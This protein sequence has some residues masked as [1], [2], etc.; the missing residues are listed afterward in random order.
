[1]S[2]PTMSDVARLAGVSEATVSRTLA[3][4]GKVA[5]ATRERVESAA[6]E[7]GYRV[8][9]V[10]R[11][12]R[13]G[14]ARIIGLVVSDLTNPFF[15]ALARSCEDAAAA[16]GYSLIISNTDESPERESSS[17]EVM[18]AERVAG[19]LLASTNRAGDSIDAIRHLGIPVV[20]LDRR[21]DGITTDTVVVDNFAVGYQAATHLADL[22]HERIAIIRGPEEVSSLGERFAGFTQGLRERGL[23]LEDRYVIAGDLRSTGGYRAGRELLALPSPPTAVFSANNLATL[24]LLRAVVEL[25]ISVPDDL[26]IVGVDDIPGSELFRPALS[27]IRQPTYQLGARAIEALL[28]RVDEPE[29]PISEIVL[30]ATFEPRGSTAAPRL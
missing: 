25:E 27:T 23:A 10:A 1:M 17:I 8:N 26:S 14:K 7:L 6:R 9:H 22:G 15:T 30:A 18:A 5:P 28:D 21:I 29:R 16:R 19:V 24:G 3:N 13:S 12:M 11:N 2:T 4:P 20:A